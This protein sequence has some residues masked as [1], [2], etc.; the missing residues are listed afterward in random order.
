MGSLGDLR[1]HARRARR[2]AQFGVGG[3]HHVLRAE[4]AVA[5]GDVVTFSVDG[6]RG[7]LIA[8]AMSPIDA[9]DLSNKLT[10]AAWRAHYFPPKPEAA[11]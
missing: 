9:V 2:L 1:H 10:S 5:D 6:S 3:E 8:W 7:R 4:I 11:K